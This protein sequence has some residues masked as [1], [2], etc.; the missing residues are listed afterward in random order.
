MKVYLVCNGEYSD[1]HV[2]EIFSTR[3]LANQ[4]ID[5][6]AKWYKCTKK[7]YTIET[8]T[9]DK[10]VSELKIIQVHMDKEGNTTYMDKEGNTTY[11]F[12]TKDNIIGFHGFD[13]GNRLVWNVNT[14]NDATSVKIVNEKRIQI[15]AKDIW[16]SEKK[17]KEMFEGT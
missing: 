15:L 5:E 3:K 14:D 4:Y 16:G 6:M 11:M 8:Y 17:V 13:Y 1:Y 9:I 12:H 10:P 7:S 2:C